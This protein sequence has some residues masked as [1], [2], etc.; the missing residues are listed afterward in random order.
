[1]KCIKILYKND[2]EVTIKDQ[3]LVKLNSQINN[4]EKKILEQ[5]NE[6]TELTKK[7]KIVMKLGDKEVFIFKFILK[8]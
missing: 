1:M 2:Q 8:N 7:A 3:A 5:E 4:L 6:I